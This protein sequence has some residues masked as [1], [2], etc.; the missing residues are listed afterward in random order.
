MASPTQWAWVWVNSGS[1]WCTGRPGVLQSM[2]SLGV[3]HDW[4]TELNW[5]NLTY[6]SLIHFK[7]IFVYGVRGCSDFIL[8][9]LGL[10]FSQYH[11]LKK[12]SFLH[13]VFLPLFLY[14]GYKCV[15]L[16]L[17]FLFCSIVLCVFLFLNQ[18]H[19]VL[20]TV[21]LL[22]SLNLRSMVPSALFFLKIVL[23][24]WSIFSFYTNFKIYIFLKNTHWWPMGTWK[25]D[26]H[27]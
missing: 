17:D 16:S 26:Q 9:H 27:C 12:L 11:L 3:E 19:S 7:I 21:A 4:V 23:A 2:G 18:Y 25:D 13:Y 14:I 5:T 8:L 10:Q 22:Y 20:I 15:S 24:I 6:R 1:W